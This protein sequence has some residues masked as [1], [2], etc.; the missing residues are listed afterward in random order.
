M[1]HSVVSYFFG[2]GEPDRSQDYLLVSHFYGHA[3]KY[4]PVVSCFFGLGEPTYEQGLSACVLLFRSMQTSVNTNLYFLVLL[5]SIV[6]STLFV[7]M[8]YFYGLRKATYELESIYLRPTFS[9]IL[10][11]IVSLRQFSH[12]SEVTSTITPLYYSSSSN[13]MLI[14]TEPN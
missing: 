5:F 3:R 1:R 6:S 8:S 9:V 4:H 7:A 13:F 10:S 11:F 2:L 14:F 12:Q